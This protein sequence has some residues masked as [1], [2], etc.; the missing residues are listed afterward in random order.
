MYVLFFFWLSYLV[1]KHYKI[2]YPSECIAIQFSITR[3]NV[4]FHCSLV[5]PPRMLWTGRDI[6]GNMVPAMLRFVI[7][8]EIQWHHNISTDSSLLY[9]RWWLYPLVFCTPRTMIPRPKT[10][11]L[12]DTMKWIEDKFKNNREQLPTWNWH[13]SLSLSQS[14]MSRYTSQALHHSRL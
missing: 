8:E 1:I 10:Q 12:V 4:D 9:R 14:M 2:G 5:F 7:V 3:I 13:I 6:A 11:A